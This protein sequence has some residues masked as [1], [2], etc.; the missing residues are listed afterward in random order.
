MEKNLILKYS[1]VFTA[2][3]LSVAFILCSCS[4]L[5][6]TLSDPELD[7]QVKELYMA[8][9]ENDEG[10]INSFFREGSEGL[11]KNEKLEITGEYSRM[12]LLSREVEVNA[13]G[14]EI[15]T[16]RYRIITTEKMYVML[17]RY[18]TDESGQGFDSAVIAFNQDNPDSPSD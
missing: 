10:K 7:K 8:I 4:T 18:I 12:E 2:F 14:A 17:I 3:F 11:M 9:A 5:M 6:K 15:K 13:E 1:T 16:A